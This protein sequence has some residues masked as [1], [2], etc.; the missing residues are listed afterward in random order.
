RWQSGG[1]PAKRATRP[2]PV[3]SGER[4]EGQ[5]LLLCVEQGYGDMIQFARF[6]A[7]LKPL[8]GK[9]FV[10][11]PARLT[12]LLGT[13]P[14]I[15]R[16]VSSEQEC[17]EAHYQLPLMSVPHILCTTLDTI[18]KKIPYLFANPSPKIDRT[19]E[20]HKNRF[21]VG[22]CWTGN[23]KNP[24]NAARSCSLADFA[25]LSK[26]PGISLFSLQ[27]GTPEHAAPE[28]DELQITRLEV[29]QQD[30]ADAASIMLRLD[31]VITIDT[32]LAHL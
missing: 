12:R 7:S 19:F 23:P 5:T 9:V 14:G 17:E 22:I 21:K 32:A 30:L 11:C 13:C 24:L 31:L 10:E 20:S 15:D 26:L 16:L 25:V 28:L 18:P 3:W 1:R 6:A 2:Q 27:M 4:F 29:L 8:G